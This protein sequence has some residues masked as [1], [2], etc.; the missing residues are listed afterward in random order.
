[1]GARQPVVRFGRYTADL[2]TR[3]LWRDNVRVPL[4][5]QPFLVL[6]QLLRRPGDL[7]TRDEL[8]RVI[9]AEGTFVQF[10]RGLTSAMRKVREALDDRA[11]QP[12]FIET[13]TGRGYR[14]IAPVTVAGGHAAAAPPPR[15]RWVPQLAAMLIVGVSAGGV[16]PNTMAA[17]RLAAAEQLSGYACL[18]KSQG[19]FAEGLAA[20]ERAH[21]L[22]PESARFTAELGLHLHAVHRYDEEM[23]MLQRAVR[24]DGASADAW[25][26][27]G[28]GYARRSNFDEAIPALER[29]GH[30]A[31]SP[32]RSTYWLTWARQQK[33]EH[34]RPSPRA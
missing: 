13:L 15:A 32:E 28:L 10:E 9:W 8:R 20:I 14:F 30:L 17:E 11:A 7:V 34:S 23:Q 6:E 2:H 33:L 12:V 1:M 24:Q 3:E 5:L 21:A 22:A 26:H 19:R 31:R 29:A 16:G 25:L 27:L 4:Q 18:L